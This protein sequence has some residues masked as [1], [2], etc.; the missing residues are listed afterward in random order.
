MKRAIPLVLLLSSTSAMAADGAME[1]RNWVA[2]R[3]TAD[4]HVQIEVSGVAVDGA[5]CRVSGTVRKAFA[6]KAAAGDAAAFRLPCGADAFWPAEKLKSARVVEAFLKQGLGGSEAVDDGQGLRVLAAPTDKPQSVD[7]PALVREMTESIARYRIDAETKRRNPDG[8][9]ALARVDDPVMRARLLAHAAG[10]LTVHRLNGADA[11]T[12]EALAAVKALPDSEM[13]LEAGLVALES[14]AMGQAKAGA[15]ALAGLLEPEVDA[16]TVPSRRDAATLVLYGARIRSD[17]PAGAFVSLSKLTD[18]ATRRDRLSNMPFAQ[19]EFSPVNPES[20]GWMDRLLTGAEALPAGDFRT[21]ALTRLCRTAQRAAM[22]MTRMPDL[23][24]KAATMAEVAARHRHAPSAQLL[25]LIREAQGGAAARA[26]AARWH[27][28]SA[29][30]FDG[31]LKSRSEALK[32]LATFTP[33]ERSAA[34][35]LLAPGA[36]GEASP[37]RLVELAEK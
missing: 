36:S 25:A 31:N 2:R 33:A 35:R 24:D 32:T 21:E 37:A 26:E 30:G 18:P 15:L 19:K 34:A 1:A 10:L 23:M 28:V 4:S 11:A 29:V 14:L 22:E 20:P 3:L 7:D 13:R 5:A 16:L 27:A 9:L 6:G 12:D 8:A 17:D